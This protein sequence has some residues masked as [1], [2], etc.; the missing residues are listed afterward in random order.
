MY[1]CI[2]IHIEYILSI[3]HDDIYIYIYIYDRRYIIDV[4]DA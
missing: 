1:P 2:L 3:I 4:N